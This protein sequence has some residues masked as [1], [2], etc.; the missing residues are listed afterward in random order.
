[1]A[2]KATVRPDKTKMDRMVRR[3]ELPCVRGSG[4]L[5]SGRIV[6]DTVL[7]SMQRRKKCDEEAKK[8][9]IKRFEEN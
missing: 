6:H 3:R 1:M 5:Y 8:E 4:P 9:A 2:Q 7:M